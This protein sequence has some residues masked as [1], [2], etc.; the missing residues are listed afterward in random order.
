VILY[1]EGFNRLSL[2]DCSDCYRLERLLPGG[3][4]TRWKTVPLHGALNK[5]A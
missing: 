1:T 3:I 4:R 2:Y 5:A